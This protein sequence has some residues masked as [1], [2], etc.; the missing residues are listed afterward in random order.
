MSFGFG[1][2]TYASDA[3]TQQPVGNIVKIK[4]FGVGGGGCN[5]INRL[6]KANVEGVEFIASNTDMMALNSVSADTKIR[7]SRLG[8]SAGAIGDCLLSRSKYLNQ[9]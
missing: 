6:V 9:L 8:R 7:F 3:D 4:I 2:N 5:A 1:E